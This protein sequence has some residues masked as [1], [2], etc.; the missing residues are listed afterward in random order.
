MALDLVRIRYVEIALPV[1][2][3]LQFL[4]ASLAN[5]LE[6]IFSREQSKKQREQIFER[7]QNIKKIRRFPSH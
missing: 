4:T 3:F 5:I 7:K 1:I 2:Y 6:E